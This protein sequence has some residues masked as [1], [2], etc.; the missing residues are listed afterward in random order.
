M[1]PSFSPKVFWQP[2][3]KTNLFVIVDLEN[4]HFSTLSLVLKNEK[5]LLFGVRKKDG[6]IVFSKGSWRLKLEKNMRL[7]TCL[8]SRNRHGFEEW[9]F[10]HVFV[11]DE[12]QTKCWMGAFSEDWISPFFKRFDAPTWKKNKLFYKVKTHP[13]FGEWR[14]FGYFWG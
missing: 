9:K 6:D 3:L 14:F 10:L 13:I 8:A 5:D 11:G 12:I 2:K 4:G 7:P 1:S